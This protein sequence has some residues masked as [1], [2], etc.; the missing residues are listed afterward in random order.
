V[1]ELN[2]MEGHN[3]TANGT[4]YCHSG[5]CLDDAWK[6]TYDYFYPIGKEDGL[7]RNDRFKEIV[8]DVWSFLTQIR[9]NIWLLRNESLQ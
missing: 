1:E 6:E 4:Y 9:L 8:E 5:K 2:L 3:K 7:K